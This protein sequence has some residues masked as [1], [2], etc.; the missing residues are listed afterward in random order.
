MD[1]KMKVVSVAV[2]L[3]GLAFA[4]S[5]KGA[6][7]QWARPDLVAKVAS[8]EV[9]EAE[10]S[11]WGFDQKDSTRYIQAALDSKARKIVLDKR[12]S[13][14]ITRP[15]V[16]RS[17]LTLVIPEGVELCAKRGE[18]RNTHDMMLMFTAATNLTFTG[19][20][21]MK[22]WFEDYTN[23]ALYAWLRLKRRKK[24]S[25]SFSIVLGEL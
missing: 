8:G 4:A 18:Y 10:V 7:G 12:E 3:S 20:G 2:A 24:D 16:G 1:V 15:L 9:C 5:E 21:T 14:W 23:S 22:M 25:A 11:W 17:N 19:G 13:A 6:E